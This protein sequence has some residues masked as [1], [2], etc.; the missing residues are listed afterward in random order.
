MLQLKA[1]PTT[2]GESG[3]DGRRVRVVMEGE[4]RKRGTGVRPRDGNGSDLG[5][6]KLLKKI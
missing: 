3:C 1:K 2:G 4:G 6:I 5:F